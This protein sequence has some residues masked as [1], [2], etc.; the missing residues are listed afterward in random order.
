MDS[1][2]LDVSGCTVLELGAGAGLPSLTAALSGASAV[3]ATDYGTFSD[4]TLMATLR[5]NAAA[6]GAARAAAGGSWCDVS[7]EPHIWGGDVA[8]LLQ[9][10]AH[11][12][13]GR[14]FDRILLADLLFNRQSH[15]QLLA[16]CK[17][18]MPDASRALM[19]C[20]ETAVRVS[21]ACL[22]PGGRVWV[23]YSHHDPGKAALDNAFWALAPAAGFAARK[24]REVQFASDLFEEGDG[25]DQA[26]AVVYFY[27]L[28]HD[29]EVQAAA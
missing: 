12:G 19:L 8:P 6:L 24:V 29:G 21:Q 25:L 9:R 10:L 18:R 14:R 4:D 13:A 23:S 1:G 27:E 2:E 20:T 22:A 7:T 17:V 3:M 5:A 26:R 15:R 16:N 28:T 11:L